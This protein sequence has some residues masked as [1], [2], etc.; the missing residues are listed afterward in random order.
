VVL[1]AVER[2]QL[3][4]LFLARR[5][6]GQ[7]HAPA[8]NVAFVERYQ[9]ATHPRSIEEMTKEPVSYGHG[10]FGDTAI[11]DVSARSDRSKLPLSSCTL[12][13]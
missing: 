3:V 9:F 13:A 7:L 12:S 8:T 10:L 11:E 6:S 2:S 4:N 5:L 1:I